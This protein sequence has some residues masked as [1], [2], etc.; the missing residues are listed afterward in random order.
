[1]IAPLLTNDREPPA[2]VTKKSRH[3]EDSHPPA[4]ALCEGW[5]RSRAEP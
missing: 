2:A 5:E 3:P 4:V 1:M